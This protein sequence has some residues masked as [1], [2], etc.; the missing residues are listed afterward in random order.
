[1]LFSILAHI[2]A[3]IVDGFL[4]A[5]ILGT[6][7]FQ[8]PEILTGLVSLGLLLPS[9]AVTVRRLHDVGRSGWWIFLGLLP[10]I[11]ALVLLYWYVQP[12]QTGPNRY[13]A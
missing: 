5:P 4:V 2:A 13:A 9:I 10:L 12:S 11:G 6:Q 7:M 1:M 3:S 8:G